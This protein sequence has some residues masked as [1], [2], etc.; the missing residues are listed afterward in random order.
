M[1]TL[2]G[3]LGVLVGL[4][5]WA[6]ILPP[7]TFEAAAVGVGVVVSLSGLLLSYASLAAAGI[8]SASERRGHPHDGL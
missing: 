4:V 7:P 3:M 6:G 2:L 1:L 8:A 5:V